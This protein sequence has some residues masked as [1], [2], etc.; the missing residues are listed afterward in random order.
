MILFTIWLELL[1]MSFAE[2]QLHPLLL[3]NLSEMGFHQPRAIQA[4][5]IGPILDGRDVIGLAPTGTGKTA[6]FIVPVAHLL[7]GT[8]PAKSVRGKK[9]IDPAAR[10][11]A[12]VLCP[13]RELAQQVQKDAGLICRGTV[14]RTCVAY[15]KVA[16]SPQAQA[17]ARGVD[18]LI[19]TP[20]RV[21]ELLDA[22]LVSLA[23][24]RHVVVDEADRMLDF[25]FLPQLS[26]TL[27]AIPTHRQIMLF[28]ATM[29]HEVAQLADRFLR[30]PV[31]VEIESHSRPAA[32]VEQRLLRVH[33][34]EKTP[35]LMHLLAGQE[36]KPRRGVLVFCRT[37][38]RVGWVG[39]ALM[40]HGI[41]VGMIHGDRSQAQRNRTLSAFAEGE[42]DVVIATDVA[43]R[44]LHIPT[45]RTVVNYDLP[46]PSMPEEYVHRVGRAGHGGGG[47]TVAEAF[48]LLDPRDTDH[49][50]A[51]SSAIG[52]DLQPEKPHGFDPSRWGDIARKK[53][54]KVTRS[55]VQPDHAVQLKREPR[56]NKRDST[57]RSRSRKS[58]PIRTGDKPGAGVK[59]LR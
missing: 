33:E 32:H 35:L 14:L 41:K 57:K 25:G 28:S 34:R 21:R 46:A 44:G 13:T 51:I 18:I 42:I 54:R 15:G 20:G 30:H 3:R 48:T 5:A 43:A 31:R 12:L 36:N 53:S 55:K 58:R 1:E 16:I 6:A 24:V 9:V 4:Q 29:P 11:R 22:G 49:W 23:S 10:L 56:A 47:T 40:R 27:E 50:R 26:A 37:R 8:K 2:F 17:L 39:A 7:L 19:A 45:V 59:K 38:R 52:V